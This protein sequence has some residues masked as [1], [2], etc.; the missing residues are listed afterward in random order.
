MFIDPP[1][2][3]FGLLAGKYREREPG[4]IPLPRTPHEL[5]AQHKDSWRG[6]RRCTAA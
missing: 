5:W 1:A 6:L 4:R 3:Q 2:R